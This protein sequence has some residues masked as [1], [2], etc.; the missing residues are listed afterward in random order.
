[1]ETGAARVEFDIDEYRER[2]ESRLGR[3]RQMV[4]SFIHKARMNSIYEGIKHLLDP[5]PV[6]SPM[7]NY[8]VIAVAVV[9]EGFAWFF[10]FKEFRAAKGKLGYFRAVREGKDPTLFVV[11]FE[12]SAAMLGL[13]VAFFGIWLGQLTGIPYF[14]GGA[15]I[16]IGLL[17]GGVAIWLAYETKSGKLAWSTTVRTERPHEPAHVTGGQ[18]VFADIEL[19]A[20]DDMH[21]ANGD[22]SG[23]TDSL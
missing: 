2:L 6:S 15:S 5:H 9:F 4:R 23:G 21:L 19:A 7:V 12:D 3:E 10:A 13:L 14:D 16:V 1:M 20:V 8:V 11:L 22:A 17:L 18:P